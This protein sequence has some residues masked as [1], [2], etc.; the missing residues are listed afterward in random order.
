MPQSD[1]SHRLSRRRFLASNGA[2]L[3]AAGVAAGAVAAGDARDRAKLAKQGGPKAVT[4]RPGPWVRW[5]EREQGQ[6]RAAVGQASL[7]YW[8]GRGAN[9]QTALFA[10]RF[11]RH[12]PLEHVVTCSSGTAAVHIAVAAAG[13]GPGD[14]VITTPITDLGTVTG[15]LFQQAVP[16]FADL[17]PATYNLDPAAVERAIT[18]RTKAIVAVHLCGTPCDLTAL[19]AIADR[20]GLFLIEDCAQAWGARHRGRPVGTFGH[21]ACFSLMN[22]KHIGA[23]EGGVVAS[24]DPRLGPALLKFADKGNERTTPSYSWDKTAVLATNYRMSELQAAFGAAQLE[25]LE[26]IAERRAMLGRALIEEISGLPAIMP[27]ALPKDD[28]GTFWFFISGCGP[29]G[30]AARGRNSSTP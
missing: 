9:R 23:G 6:V 8:S 30:C 12:C 17:G 25:R 15:I 13:A 10:E 3:A 16:V 14:E 21:A 5:D 27:P 1:G 22:S 11:R 4:R 19:R 2:A 29:K 28:R 24:G 7:F 20:H 26:D 18:P